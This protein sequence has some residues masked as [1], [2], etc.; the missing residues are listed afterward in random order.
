[1]TALEIALV[2]A[3]KGAIFETVHQLRERRERSLALQQHRGC[4]SAE[5][6]TNCSAPIDLLPDTDK[7]VWSVRKQVS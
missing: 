3:I 4:P 2:C 1:M 7:Q 6:T 5:H